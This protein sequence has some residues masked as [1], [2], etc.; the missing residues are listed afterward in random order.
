L[1]RTTVL[2]PSIVIGDW[3]TGRTTSFNGFYLALRAMRA[4]AACVGDEN[5]ADARRL[6]MLLPGSA[7]DVQNLV[8]VDYVARVIAAIV[9]APERSA[10]FY[11]ITHPSPPSNGMILTAVERALGVRGFAFEGDRAAPLDSNGS[12]RLFARLIEPIFPYVGHSPAFARRNVDAVERAEGITCPKYDHDALTRT[13][14]F[15]AQGLERHERRSTRHEPAAL[16]AMIAHY[17]EHFLPSRVAVSAVA[18]R[19]GLSATVKFDITD[20]IDGQ[21]TCVFDAGRVALVRRASQMLRA[22]FGYRVDASTF[23][24]VISAQADPQEMFLSG[25]VDLFGDVERALKMAMVLHQF[26]REFAFHGAALQRETVA[27]A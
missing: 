1:R 7:T 26:S 27:H 25:R 24:Q 18:Q 20:L 2:R 12:Q 23:L 16:D 19:I 10:L 3:T 5:D 22:D 11:N 8:P 9:T 21:W 14:A 13:C 4:A 6:A 15:A 17:F